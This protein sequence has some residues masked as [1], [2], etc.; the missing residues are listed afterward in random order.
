MTPRYSAWC[1]SLRAPAA[2]RAAVEA[3]GG[4]VDK[5]RI[6]GDGWTLTDAPVSPAGGTAPVAARGG[7]SGDELAVDLL[8]VET[9]H[10]LRLRATS[11]RATAEWATT[12]LHRFPPDNGTPLHTLRTPRA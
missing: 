12:P 5:I 4:R 10:R 6:G 3:D 11:S 2:A 8:F 7:W 9:P 1:S